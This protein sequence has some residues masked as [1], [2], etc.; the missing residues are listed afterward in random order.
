MCVYGAVLGAC[1]LGA[2]I[3]LAAWSAPLNGPPTCASGNPGCDAPVNVGAT[4]QTK[5]GSLTVSGSGSS[6]TAPQFCIGAS[7]ITTWPSGGGGGLSGSGSANY[8]PMWGSDGTS[9]TNSTLSDSGGILEHT[10]PAA[11]WAME[12]N[13]PPSAAPEYGI[14]VGNSEY[15][16]SQFQNVA[17]YVTELANSSWGVYTNGNI[18]AANYYIDGAY[19]IYGSGGMYSLGY[20]GSSYAC[21]PGYAS[22]VNPF[23]GTCSCLPGYTAALAAGILKN[24]I[25]SPGG[26]TEIYYCYIT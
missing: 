7:C 5:S 10:G 4:A 26:L 8:I 1:A 24:T 19:P 20:N 14:L 3:A 16:Y 23:T 13:W 15:G 2:S 25:P 12:I 9:L 18:T 17:G 6:I 21:T 11:N 22:A